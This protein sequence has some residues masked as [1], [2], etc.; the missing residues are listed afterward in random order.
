[1]SA[2]TVATLMTALWMATTPPTTPAPAAPAPASPVA[3]LPPAVAQEMAA[4]IVA[5]NK[6]LGLESWPAHGAVPCVD[7]G[8]EGTMA[9]DVSAADTR[10]CVD[11]ALA[12]GFP[13]LGKSYALAVS[14]TSY[15]PSTVIAVGTAD[16]AGFGA[17]SCDPGRKCLPTK[18]QAS[19]KWGKRLLER[20]QK[21]CAET[22]TVW[23]PANGR[24]CVP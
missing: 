5:V 20:Q 18:M 11:A 14:M 10:R 9:K 15:G 3:K 22:E 21:A 16:A 24:V 23:F 13:L 7:R 17:Y 1:M 12:S 6:A 19:T 4:A 8:G 2:M